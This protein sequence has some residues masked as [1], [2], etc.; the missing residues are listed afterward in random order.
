[1]AFSSTLIYYS[2]E[3][4]AICLASDILRTFRY[5]LLLV[6]VHCEHDGDGDERDREEE[7]Q[8]DGRVV[9]EE[10]AKV[11]VDDQLWSHRRCISH[12]QMKSNRFNVKLILHLPP[13]KVSVVKSYS[14]T[15]DPAA[16]WA[17]TLSVY[18][19]SGRRSKIRKYLLLLLVFEL[20]FS[21]VVSASNLT[22]LLT[23]TQLD[24]SKG[25]ASEEVE[26]RCLYSITKLEEH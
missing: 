1:M 21:F 23:S 26:S 13:L 14:L 5:E 10:A 18:L 8:H 7:G 20:V 4:Y 9:Q 24:V 16:L 11:R 17:V 3:I 12:S 6:V 22:L 15:V 19:V 25:E 2:P